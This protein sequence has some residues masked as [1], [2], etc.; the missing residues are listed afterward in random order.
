ML[1][2][3]VKEKQELLSALSKEK[4]ALTK[5]LRTMVKDIRDKKQKIKKQIRAQAEAQTEAFLMSD[6]P[7]ILPR[8]NVT[9]TQ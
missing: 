9:S 6:N 3:E 2:K 8:Y 4:H 5:K 7:P 1:A